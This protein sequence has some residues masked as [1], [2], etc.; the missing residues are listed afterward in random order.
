MIGLLRILKS[1]NLHRVMV[2]VSWWRSNSFGGSFVC[3]IT[4]DVGAYFGSIGLVR[5]DIQVS[6]QKCAMFGCKRLGQ[7]NMGITTRRLRGGQSC[8]LILSGYEKI[9]T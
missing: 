9:D 5:L 2:I 3:G 4:R 7:E 6:H 1:R 8:H